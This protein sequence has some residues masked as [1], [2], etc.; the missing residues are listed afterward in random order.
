MERKDPMDYAA[1]R[2]EQGRKTEQLILQTALT[3]MR[4]RGFDK[5]SVRDICREAGITT[6]A[7]YHHFSSKE[8][9]FKK[10]FSPLDLYMERA[11]AQDDHTDPSERLRVILVNYARFI[12]HECGELTGQYYQQ[13]VMAPRAVTPMDPTRYIQTAM[14]DCLRRAEAD[15]VLTTG[16][17]PE[18]L[19]DFCY[20][21]FRGVVIDWVLHNYDYS[22]LDK[23]TEDY[24]LFARLF[25]LT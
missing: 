19:A 23:M 1:R 12:E 18:W 5:V 16:H 6:G 3:L 7:F 10:G 25:K 2:Q 8:A 17:T 15:G 11:M 24:E 14:L 13:R 9:L 20:R 4:R 21:H 22:L